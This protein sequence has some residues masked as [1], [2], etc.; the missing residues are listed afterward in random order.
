LWANE[1]IRVGVADNHLPVIDR[2]EVD[3]SRFVRRVSNRRR[4]PIKMFN[5]GLRLQEGQA[6]PHW[7]VVAIS[8]DPGFKPRAAFV[9]VAQRNWIGNE[10]NK[11]QWI[12]TP[13]D[14]LEHLQSGAVYTF[15]TTFAL[16]GVL[17]NTA[18]VQGW[19]VVN[20]HVEG[21]RLNGESVPIPEHREPAHKLYYK[22]RIDHGF[23]EGTNVLDFD[24]TNSGTSSPSEP[25]SAMAFRVDLEGT[26]Q[27]Q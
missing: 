2:V 12:S 19:F 26:A 24:V 1:S 7:Q 22:F 18:V 25:L 27:E 3:P 15:R 17:P 5:T 6:D 11:S 8:S 21:I 23:I 14:R 9:I 16:N 4:I 20:R 13:A 10:P